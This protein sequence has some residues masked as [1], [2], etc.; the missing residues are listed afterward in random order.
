MVSFKTIVKKFG[1]K[2]EKTGWTYFEITSEQAEQ[3]KPANK[4]SFRVKGKI[5]NL[6]ISKAALLPLGNG[7]FILPLNS[8]MRKKTGIRQGEMIQ[9][10]LTEDTTE[11]ILNADFMECLEQDEAGMTYFK[12]LAPSH[13]KYFSK[14]IEQAKSDNT[15]ANRIAKTVNALARQ[16][17]FSMMMREGKDAST[18]SA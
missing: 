10:Q 4:K 9:V 11:I 18:S 6:S 12:S 13:Q 14:W 17:N 2:G 8:E 15:R 5:N 16:M 7:E 1:S 3:L